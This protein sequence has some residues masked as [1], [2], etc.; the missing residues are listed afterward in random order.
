MYDLLDYLSMVE[1]PR[2]TRAY[3][4]AMSQVIRPGDVVLEIGTGFGFF[5]VH[6]A[7][8]GARLVHAVEPSDAIAYGPV[9]AAAN[10]VEDRIRFMQC[11]STR[12][13]L[14]EPA[15]VLIEDLRGTSP[16]HEGRLGALLDAR[17][18]LL[19]PGARVIPRL[20]RLLVAPAPAPRSLA[21][22]SDVIGGIDVG[23][24]RARLAEAWRRVRADEVHPLAPAVEWA[25]VDYADFES[26][27]IDG[28][29]TC[30]IATAGRIEGIASWFEATLAP[31]VTYHTG[32]DAGRT[33][34][35]VGW[36]PL[37]TPIEAREGDTVRMRLRA[38][39]D[40]RDYTW[41]WEAE[42]T[43]VDG[44]APAISQRQSNLLQRALS[45]A[46]RSRR[47][48]SHV[49]RLGREASLLSGALALADGTRTMAQVA[50]ALRAATGRSFGDD[51]E[52]L[53]WVTDRLA[54]LEEEG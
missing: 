42:W 1:D 11:R 39:H 47:A 44:R 48:A 23:A 2:R 36:F 31:G 49:P 14:D 21:T 50:S 30:V 3:L 35:D 25:S 17:R 32:P 19:R 18:R 6:A 10:G 26:V 24:V 38:K 5:A 27:D 4:D 33:V 51:A 7:R 41:S 9:V 8:L 22:V 20:D 52:A 46:R 40:G 29:A 15:D 43:P 34:Y 16:L 28:V 13:T 54:S 53:R 37:V 12:L 45:P